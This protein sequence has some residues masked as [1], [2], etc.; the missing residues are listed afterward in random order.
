MKYNFQTL[1]LPFLGQWEVGALLCLHLRGLLS[2]HRLPLLPFP[3]L[4]TF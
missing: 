3:R 4:R 2:E 1:R